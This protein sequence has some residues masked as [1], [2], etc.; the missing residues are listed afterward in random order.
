MSIIE[1]LYGH[2][3]RW[4]RIRDTS[5]TWSREHLAAEEKCIQLEDA[6]EVAMLKAIDERPAGRQQPEPRVR[7]DPRGLATPEEVN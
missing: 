6:I 1:E 5:D 4:E 2:L 7:A 3:R